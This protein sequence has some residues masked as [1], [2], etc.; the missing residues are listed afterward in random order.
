MSPLLTLVVAASLA[1]Q[2][3]Q[4]T[5]PAAEQIGRGYYLFLQGLSQQAANDLAG[6]IESY[7]QASVVLPRSPEILAQLAELYARQDQLVDAERE[8]RAALAI[9]PGN[10]QAHRILGG[11][12]TSSI[13]GATGVVAPAVV[14]AAIGHL[15]RAVDE[16]AVDPPVDLAL[17]SLYIRATRVDDAIARLSKILEEIPDYPPALRLLIRAYEAEGRAEDA[18]SLRGRLAVARP[19]TTELRVR[20]IDRLEQGG[21]WSDAAAEW[22]AVFADDPGASIYRTR[23]AAAL[24]NSGRVQE[25]RRMLSQATAEAPKDSGAWYLLAVVESRTGNSAAAEAAALRVVALDAKDGRGPLALARARF[26]AKNYRGVVQALDARVA[27]PPDDDVTSGLFAEMAAELSRAY[28]AMGQAKRGFEVLER[29]RRR[30][31]SDEDLLF[32]LAAGYEQQREYD[33]AERTFRDLIQLNATHAEA[34]N[35]L[36]YMLA[37]RGVKLPEAVSLISRALKEDPDNPSFL[38]SLGWAHFRLGD[39]EKAREPLERAAAALPRSSLV[40]EHLGDLY[41][42]LSR[43]GDAAAA[44]D[45][46]LAGDRDGIDVAI[47]TKKRDRARAAAKP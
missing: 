37:D 41:V 9:D 8:A 20:R 27:A 45:R 7:R 18:G 40:Q 24:A 23:Y 47:L 10:R 21:R 5:P 4:P 46:A 25:A 32:Q 13:E 3:P 33:R 26:A 29:A 6:A 39:Y 38:D 12:Q 43:A 2:S 44:F 17:A 11:I 42:Q 22:A 35:Y 16:G 14:D 1:L 30:L 34:L 36:G 28:T 19:D 31:P 15:E